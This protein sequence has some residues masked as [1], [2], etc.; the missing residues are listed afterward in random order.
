MVEAVVDAYRPDAEDA[1]RFLGAEVAAGVVIHGDREL[2]TQAAA[3][4]VENA[5][6]HTPKGTHVVVR[7]TPATA[8][9]MSL[10]VADDGPGVAPGELPRITDRF[11][12]TERSRTAPGNGLGLTL[13]AAVADLHAATLTLEN[14]HP[15]L[16]ATLSFPARRPATRQEISS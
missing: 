15:G 14:A 16:R 8:A 13:V 3:N 10:T 5:L 4:L 1:G 7:L 2:L 12:R 9:G 11:Y 6:A